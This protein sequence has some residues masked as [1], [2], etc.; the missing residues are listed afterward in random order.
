VPERKLESS[1]D[2]SSAIA[3]MEGPLKNVNRVW[4]CEM[5]AVVEWVGRGVKA[6]CSD[7]LS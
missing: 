1:I 3:R 7:W 2:Q 5:P 6:V 4:S